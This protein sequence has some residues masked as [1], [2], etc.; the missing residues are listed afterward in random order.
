[1]SAFFFLV[2]YMKWYKELIRSIAGFMGRLAFKCK[3][4]CCSCQSECMNDP[5]KELDFIKEPKIIKEKEI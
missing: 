1:M 2:I 3:G 4:N 5:Q